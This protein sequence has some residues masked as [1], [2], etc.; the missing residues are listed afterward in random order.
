MVSVFGIP[1]VASETVSDAAI[2][3]AGSIMAEYLDNNEDGTEDQAIVSQNM[4]DRKALLFL[5]YDEEEMESKADWVILEMNFYA[6]DLFEVET[7]PPDA[8]DAS[9]E[10]VLHLI[11]DTGYAGA[12]PQIAPSKGNDLSA[13]MDIARGGSFNQVPDQYPEG[14]WYHYD[15]QSCSYSCMMTEYFYWGL[16]TLLGAQSQRCS[17]IEEEWALCLP[18]Q[19][20]QRD[21]A[22]F[23]LLTHEDYHL[24]TALPN[25]R[26]RD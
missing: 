11:Q 5:F 13:A 21:P 17:E 12:Y 16:T 2:I 19:I 6:Q 24:P 22:L 15:D 8:F 26:Y 18:E 25:G 20:P 3:H 9:L 10:E 4:R 23:E 1:I 7:N 14:A